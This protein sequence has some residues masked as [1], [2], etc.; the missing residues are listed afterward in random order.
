MNVVI[1]I[2][3]GVEELDAIGPLEVFGLAKTSGLPVEVTLST[4]ETSRSVRGIHGV[5]FAELPE[6]SET[7]P[8]DL[9][10]VPGGAWL[11][12]THDGVRR[13][14]EQNILPGILRRH[15]EAGATVASVCTGAFLLEAAGLLATAP[16]TTHHLALDDL[17]AL[18][19]TCPAGRV[20]DAG[21]IVTCGGITS[22][23]DLALHLIERH[24]GEPAAT[25]VAGMLEYR[26]DQ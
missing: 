26:R 25:R 12:G 14:I 2:F 19:V 11:A 9:I 3:S 23:I 8:G 20:V 1:P 16:G 13:A 6:F 21:R 4:H 7:S 5:T 24:W 10:I 22:G 18:G 17:R 15:F